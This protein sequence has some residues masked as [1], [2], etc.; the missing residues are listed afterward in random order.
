MYK[1]NLTRGSCTTTIETDS[2]DKCELKITIFLH[3]NKN[4]LE[5]C[6][7][8]MEGYDP[9]EQLTHYKEEFYG[10]EYRIPRE[11]N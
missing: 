7:Y 4:S 8:T 3:E 10:K 11:K 2:V 1:L 6:S 5:N 9:V